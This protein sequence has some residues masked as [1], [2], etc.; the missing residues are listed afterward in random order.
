MRTVVSRLWRMI[1]VPL[2]IDVVSVTTLALAARLTPGLLVRPVWSLW[3]VRGASTDW[4][5]AAIQYFA[6]W[7]LMILIGL[8]LPTETRRAPERFPP[9]GPRLAFVVPI[10]S[11]VV[12]EVTYRWLA[13]LAGA[14]ALRA[15]ETAC[16]WLLPAAVGRWELA[17]SALIVSYLFVLAH[18]HK[19]PV[20]Q[21]HS[22][23][24]GLVLTSIALRYG[25]LVAM[26]IHGAKNAVALIILAV[27][28][29]RQ[30][31][32]KPAPRPAEI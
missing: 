22:Y 28:R 8:T 24:A 27:I 26:V 11:P 18:R 4:Q 31:H 15:V 14:T 21:F 23:L 9:I 10:F 32:R 2:I 30:A 7:P 5:W 20:G 17:G 25:L 16:P 3:P 29:W 12:E 1:S 19:S 13:L 6:L